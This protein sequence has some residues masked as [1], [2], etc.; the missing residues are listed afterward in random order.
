[1]GQGNPSRWIENYV[2]V[3]TPLPRERF[4]PLA[5]DGPMT[6]VP[7]CRPSRKPRDFGG[8][9]LAQCTAGKSR[10][11]RAI[12][13][14]IQSGRSRLVADS[15]NSGQSSKAIGVDQWRNRFRGPWTLFNS[16]EHRIVDDHALSYWQ[17]AMLRKLATGPTSSGMFP[18]AGPRT[19]RWLSVEDVAR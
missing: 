17:L 16:K 11:A 18:E 5:G 19:Q 3:N 9:Y 15:H 6:C 1:M 14:Q 4:S 8:R 7:H 12:R 2:S 13:W 10:P